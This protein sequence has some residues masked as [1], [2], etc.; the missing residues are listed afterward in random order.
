[1]YDGSNASRSAPQ[2]P[3]PQVN[4]SSVKALIRTIVHAIAQG[5]GTLARATKIAKNKQTAQPSAAAADPGAAPDNICPTLHV[6]LSQSC[7]Q[8][9]GLWRS[10]SGK[11]TSFLILLGKSYVLRSAI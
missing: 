8:R 7:N 5:K 11:V 1:M 9:P 6:Y 3:K 2:G 4:L 10:D